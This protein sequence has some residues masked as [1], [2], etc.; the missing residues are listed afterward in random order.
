[1]TA[2]EKLNKIKSI[3]ETNPYKDLNNEAS[4]QKYLDEFVKKTDY[5]VPKEHLSA[6]QLGSAE[7]IINYLVKYILGNI[8]N[9]INDK[10]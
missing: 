2:I 7:A 6:Y 9:I 4:I 5:E 3:I 10:K 1:M 8:N